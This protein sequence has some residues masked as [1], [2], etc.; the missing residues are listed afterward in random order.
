MTEVCVTEEDLS[1]SYKNQTPLREIVSKMIQEY[2]CA[3]D[4][5]PAQKLYEMVIKEVELGLFKTVLD[6]TGGNQSKAAD[7]LGL[8][9]GTL[10]KRLAEYGL[11]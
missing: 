5:Q 6:Y 10:R 7:W 1:S 8:A 11:E 4:G 2:F 3:L 9:R